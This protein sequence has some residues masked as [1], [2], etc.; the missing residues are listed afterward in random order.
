ME[1]F[2]TGFAV[3]LILTALGFLLITI[4]A[5]WVNILGLEKQKDKVKE[6]IKHILKYVL[7]S[8]SSEEK[9]GKKWIGKIAF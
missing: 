5:I 8:W 2:K 3:L 7:F 1:W 4:S 9:R 6:K